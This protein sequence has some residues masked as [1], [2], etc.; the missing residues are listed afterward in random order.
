MEEVVAQKET[1]GD[2]AEKFSLFS[3]A[4]EQFAAMGKN[5]VEEF[6]KVQTDL[7]DKLQDMNRQWLD[8][9]NSEANLASQLASHVTSARS[10]PDAMTAC[11]QWTSRRF[12]MMAE[13]GQH[14]FTDAQ[15]LAETGSRLL[16]NGWQSKS[17]SVGT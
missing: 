4:P 16:S 8:R 10:I 5:Y 2:Q 1:R 6:A 17:S 9:I 12:E 13:D 3:L 11:Q 15:K 14:L 7:F